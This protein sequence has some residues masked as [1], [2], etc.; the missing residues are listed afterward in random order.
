MKKKKVYKNIKIKYC[1]DVCY[2]F[3]CVNVSYFI[4][5]IDVRNVLACKL[6]FMFKRVQRTNTERICV[7]L[8]AYL[9]LK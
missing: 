5:A 3:N 1:Q 4:E 9:R 7:R 2:A 8:V 6:S